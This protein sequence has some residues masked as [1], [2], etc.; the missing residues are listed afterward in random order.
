M[1]KE[2]KNIDKLL[3]YERPMLVIVEAEG[4]TLLSGSNHGSSGTPPGTGDPLAKRNTM[5]D[6][7]EGEEP[8]NV[9]SK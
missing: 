3:T 9:F 7:D 6:D 4:V 2:S 8:G 1:K 5:F